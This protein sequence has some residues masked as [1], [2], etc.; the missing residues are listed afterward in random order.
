MKACKCYAGS[1]GAGLPAMASVGCQWVRGVCIAGKP[2]SYRLRGLCWSWLACDGVG[3]VSAST[4]RLHRGQARLLQVTRALLELA[5]L[6]WR[7]W[8]VSGFAVFVSR[9]SLAPTGYA[10]S[11]GAGLPA[12]VSVGCQWVRGVC[13]A[14]KPGSYRL[15]GL[16]WSWLACDGLGGVSVGSRRLYRGQAR[17]LQAARALLE[18]ACLRWRRWGAREFAVA[19]S[20]ASP[21]PTGY[22]GSV[23]AGLPAMASVR[24]Q[25]VRGVCIAGKP[26]SYRLR[27]RCWS[28][29][30]CDGVGG[31]SV[32]SRCLYRGQARLLQVT[33]A[34]L[35]LA[36]LRWRRWGVSEFAAF[37]SRASP[38]PTG[39]VGSVGA[40]LPAMASVWCQW[41]RGVCIAGKPGSYRLRGLCWSWLACDG[42]GGVSVSS[43]WLHRGQARLL[44]VARALLELACLRW[45][46]WGVS[47]FAAFASRASPAPTGYVGSVGAGLP[48]MASVGCP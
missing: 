4:R 33:W 47:G 40:G 2:G 28:W 8:G 44:Q 20:R 43:R 35:E 32:S 1:V 6:R 5:C 14:G 7:R 19:A 13:I 22:V 27:G 24:C 37:A 25:R 21:A 38:A 18:L 26:G 3:G 41:V 39:Y 11:V 46:Q 29:L 45:R 10:G 42:V 48:A 15:S 23:G 12:M 9:A 31:V 16:C 30:A 17:L 34:L 36:C